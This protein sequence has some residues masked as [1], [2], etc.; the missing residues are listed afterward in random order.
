MVAQGTAEELA[1]PGLTVTV[2]VAPGSTTTY[3]ATAEAEGI[4]S[5][6]SSPLSYKQEEPAPP[7]PVEEGGG[8][9][10]GSGGSTGGTGGSTGGTGGKSSG[11]GGGHG[12]INYVTPVPRI[13]YGPAAITRLR[14]PTFRFADATGQPGTSFFCR[15]DKKRWTGCTSPFRIR[16]VK[17]G[18]HVFS[19]KAVNAVGVPSASTVK[20][21]FKVVAR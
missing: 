11:S 6:C 21:K 19:V 7:P 1:S 4:V 5:A 10:G 9:S 13:T 17:L 18:S 2:P 15:V 14:R 20:R 12:G 16:K 8:S 3:R